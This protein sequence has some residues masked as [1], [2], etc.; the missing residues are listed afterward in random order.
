MA[1]SGRGL[2]G[3]NS[4]LAKDG[5]AVRISV[6]IGFGGGVIIAFTSGQAGCTLMNA[7]DL[8]AALLRS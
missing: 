2:G 7:A 6:F 3:S 8:S 4:S 5:Y 1:K